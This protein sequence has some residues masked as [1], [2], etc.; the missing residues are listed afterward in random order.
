MTVSDYDATSTGGDALNTHNGSAFSTLDR[1]NDNKAGGSCATQANAPF[2]FND[3][4]DTNPL[5]VYG[6]SVKWQRWKPVTLDKISFSIRRNLCKEG[7]G[8]SCTQCKPGYFL[9]TT[10]SG[11]LECCSHLLSSCEAVTI[12]GIYEIGTQG[13]SHTVYCRIIPNYGV[14]TELLSRENGS[15]DDFAVVPFD[16]FA[17]KGHGSVAGRDYI[18]PL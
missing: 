13:N 11:L 4:Y 18:Q 2:W 7:A 6:T 1:D 17:F 10:S 15:V 3:C 16:D 8:N 9:C 12:T 5:G 14:F